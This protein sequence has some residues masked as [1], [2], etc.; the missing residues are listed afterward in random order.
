MTKYTDHFTMNSLTDRQQTIYSKFS[1]TAYARE[2]EIQE[3]HLMQE[4]PGCC[5]QIGAGLHVSPH[6]I[7][8]LIGSIVFHRHT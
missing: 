7:P 2:E 6:P 4:A 1:A 3:S 5:L 8:T